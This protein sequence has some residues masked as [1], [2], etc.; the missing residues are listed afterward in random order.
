MKGNSL[1]LLEYGSDV[2]NKKESGLTLEEYQLPQLPSPPS[3]YHKCITALQDI[4]PKIQ[5]A[6]T[7]PSRVRYA[8]IHK[9]TNVFLM[10]GSLHE[11][12][13]GQAHAGQVMTYN[14]KLN[15]G[16]SLQKR[17]SILASTALA[18]SK[19]KHKDAAK[20]VLIKAQ[21]PIVF[22]ENKARKKLHERGVRG[23]KR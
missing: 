8:V 23:T 5:Q 15:A 11:M 12:K 22:A 20:S 17:R 19:K 1:E 14:S 10:R 18:K 3:S 7:S 2:K 21:K 13:I 4:N 9:Q 6:L 16:R